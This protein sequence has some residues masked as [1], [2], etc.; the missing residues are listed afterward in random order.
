MLGDR[1]SAVHRI[2]RNFK[3]GQEV[4]VAVSALPPS[5]ERADV[6]DYASR[7]RLARMLRLGL[8]WNIASRQADP[9]GVASSAD[10]A[11]ASA[12]TTFI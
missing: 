11:S 2:K 1:W 5:D 4:E 7:K 3:L 6:P 9:R 10:P 8:G 12:I